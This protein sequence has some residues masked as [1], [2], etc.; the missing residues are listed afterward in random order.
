MGNCLNT[1]ETRKGNIRYK[2]CK[3]CGVKYNINIRTCPHHTFRKK[4]N[5]FRCVHCNLYRSKFGS[6]E[7][8]HHT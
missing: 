7:C 8:Y 5:T 2:I 6:T 1:I 4:N 3:K